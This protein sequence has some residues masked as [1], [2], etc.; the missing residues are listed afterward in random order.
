MLTA[1]W[2]I[3]SVRKARMQATEIAR[4]RDALSGQV[5]GLRGELQMAKQEVVTVRRS[6]VEEKLSESRQRPQSCGCQAP[7]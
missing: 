4:E 5:D 6:V 3:N 7:K 1:A 2:L